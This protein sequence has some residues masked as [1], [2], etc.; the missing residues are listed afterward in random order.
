M[1]WVQEMV[2][3]CC[4]RQPEQRPTF[5][6][7]HAHLLQ[8]QSMSLGRMSLS[9]PRNDWGWTVRTLKAT[10]GAS[11]PQVLYLRASK[12]LWAHDLW[13]RLQHGVVNPISTC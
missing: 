3:Q 1:R 2:L 5:E 12:M 6:V 11:W 8:Y 7:L 9:T 10:G 13:V 4:S